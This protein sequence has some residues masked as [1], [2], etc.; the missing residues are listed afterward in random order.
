LKILEDLFFIQRGYLNGNHFVYSAKHPILID[1]G[2][3]SDFGDTKA[4]IEKLDV[5]LSAVRLIINTHTHCDHIGGN[6]F[7]QELSGCDIALHRIGKHFIDTRD[8]WS[9]WWK[10][11]NQKADFFDCTKALEDGD[12]VTI[13]PHAF[14]VLHTPGH[15]ADGIVLYHPKAKLLISSDALWEND[16]AVMTLRVEGSQSLFLHM[17]SLK[18][19]SRLDIEAV[20]PGHGQP[21][22]NVA[23]AISRALKRTQDL[24]ENP[25]KLG[26]DLLKKIFIYTLLMHGSV[27]EE[28]F[29][30]HLM[31]TPW[32]KETVDLYFDSA[33]EKIYDSLLHGLL[34]KGLVKQK[35]GQLFTI[36]KP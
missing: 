35:T 5:D 4:F 23:E 19:L 27:K 29:F 32:F 3:I 16:M 12:L 22:T 2:Y 8:D 25:G 33:H 10:Y 18:K 31:G 13:G 24:L 28:T 26:N 11:Y 17:D 1:T 36:V 7:I 20:Y 9:T 15:A 21:F 14:Q 34:E 6:K 30:D